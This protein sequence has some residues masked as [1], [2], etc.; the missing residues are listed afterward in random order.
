ME[1]EQ[2][3]EMA[4]EQKP[5]TA[6]RISFLGNSSYCACHNNIGTGNNVEIGAL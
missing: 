5:M 4:E 1:L 3:S 6:D 2:V